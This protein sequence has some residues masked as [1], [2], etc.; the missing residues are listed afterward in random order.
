MGKIR[1][2]LNVVGRWS[3]PFVAALRNTPSRANSA[4]AWPPSNTG[5]TGLTGNDS[6][7]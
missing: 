6:T 3:R 1:E 7:G 4:S 2:E 5:S